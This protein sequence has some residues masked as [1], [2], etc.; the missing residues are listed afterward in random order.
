M[1]EVEIEGVIYNVVAR[2]KK[3]GRHGD[4]VPLSWPEN[5][6][7]WEYASEWVWV[8]VKP[9]PVVAEVMHG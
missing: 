3:T 6:I 8:R 2:H 7:V 9:E 1:D 4:D 5:A